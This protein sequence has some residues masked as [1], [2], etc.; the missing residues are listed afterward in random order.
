MFSKVVSAEELKR[1]LKTQTKSFTRSYET[2]Q[3]CVSDIL[4]FDELNE[5]A[6]IC[7]T[8]VSNAGGYEDHICVG[9]SNNGIT[10]NG[11]EVTVYSCLSL[12]GALNNVTVNVT[13]IGY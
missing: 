13:A 1:G 6:G 8:S 2:K 3:V 4:I 9:G 5:V 10:I 12:G 11:N 7:N